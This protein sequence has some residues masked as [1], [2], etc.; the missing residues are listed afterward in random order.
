MNMSAL[1]NGVRKRATSS[2]YSLARIFGEISPSTSTSSVTMMVA[3][4]GPIFAP[5]VMIPYTVATVVMVMLD[6][7]FPTSTAVIS[8]SKSSHRLSACAARLL[9]SA[10]R[11]LSLILL[12]ELNAVSVAEKNVELSVRSIIAIRYPFII[13]FR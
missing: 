10:A 11:F 12:A 7:V 8:L 2:A 1:T 5:Q 9:S 4:V 6:I 3:M 13:P